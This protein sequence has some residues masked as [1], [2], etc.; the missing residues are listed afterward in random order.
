MRHG[1]AGERA[2]WRKSGRP[3]EE[4]PLTKDGRKKA[5]EAAKGL[6]RLVDGCGVV[7]TS[8][9]DRAAQTA[10]LVAGA[11]KSHVHPLDELIP[12][13]DFP[14]LLEWL[15]TRREARVALVGHEP[16]LSAFVS[17][18]L[19]GRERPVVALKKAQAVLL[20]LPKPAAGAATLLWSIPPKALRA[21]RR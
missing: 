6:A 8:P 2:D 7:A 10:E 4:R 19:T 18:L 3:D 1:L 9:W 11:L 13:R 12:D 17:W 14:E 20:D 21:A 16:H 15:K 5:K